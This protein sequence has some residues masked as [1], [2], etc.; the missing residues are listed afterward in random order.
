MEWRV[1]YV[2]E[3]VYMRGGILGLAIVG[4]CRA[5]DSC[6]ETVHYNLFIYQYVKAGWV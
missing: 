6:S 3:V 1:L 2:R 4:I 5:H